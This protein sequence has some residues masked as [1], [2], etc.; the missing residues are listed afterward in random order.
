MRESEMEVFRHLIMVAGT[1][2]SVTSSG[3]SLLN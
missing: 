3:D 2:S 1:K